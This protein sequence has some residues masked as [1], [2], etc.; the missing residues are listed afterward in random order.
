M[1]TVDRNGRSLYY[2]WTAAGTPDLAD[3]ST[4][5]GR[6]S[7]ATDRGDPPSFD[8]EEP[9]VVLL[10]TLGVGPWSVRWQWD[11]LAADWD[12]V[13]PAIRGTGRLTARPDG[14]V[15]NEIPADRTDDGLGPVVPRLPGPLRRRL[16]GPVGGYSI[17]GLAADLDAILADAECPDVHLVGAGLGGAVALAYALEY[18]RASTL[19]LV[20]TSAG[21]DVPPI[22]PDEVREQLLDPDGATA[23]ARKR[24]R[25]RAYFG[26]SFVARNPHLLDRLCRWQ[27]HQGP[28][29][30]VLEA[31]V[32]TWRRFDVD[33]RVP[34]LR[35]PTL[36]IHGRADRIVP[37]ECGEAL[38]SAR[39]GG[40]FEPID[41]A[42]HLVGVERPETVTARIG[43]F[44]E[45]Q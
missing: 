34:D 8:G 21:G 27:D 12:V 9:P 39:L 43:S 18:D 25:L 41:S 4:E 15:R 36:V 33:D 5:V 22:L 16:T 13:V 26:E 42:G 37:F 11:G 30:G 20:G 35:L 31:Q 3:V 44:L 6:P 28:S 1:P 32:A 17:D 19:A 45:A 7:M 24:Q 10:S 2:E 38:A 23:I 29:R 40:A 14:G